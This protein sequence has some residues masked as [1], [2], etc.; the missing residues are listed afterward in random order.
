MLCEIVAMQGEGSDCLLTVRGNE[1]LMQG[2]GVLRR[3]GGI[4]LIII[5]PELVSERDL[6][7]LEMTQACRRPFNRRGSACRSSA[8]S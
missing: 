1:N 3:G 5:R 8:T 4:G 2:S 7:H 6:T